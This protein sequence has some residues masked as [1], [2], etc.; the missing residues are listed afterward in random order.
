MRKI[1]YAMSSE[2]GKDYFTILEQ[3]NKV[4]LF[5]GKEVKKEIEISEENPISSIVYKNDTIVYTE[6]D[7]DDLYVCNVTTGVVVS[8]YNFEHYDKIYVLK[9]INNT[10]KVI[11]RA[12]RGRDAYFVLYDLEKD[13]T[14]CELEMRGK[15]YDFT[16]LQ[17]GSYI[18]LCKCEENVSMY[19]DDDDSETTHLLHFRCTDSGIEEIRKLM[20]FSSYDNFDERYRSCIMPTG[21]VRFPLFNQYMY[22][23]PVEKSLTAS[24]KHAVYYQEDI[25]GLV[26][27]DILTAD[28]NRILTLPD[29]CTEDNEYYYNDETGILSVLSGT[30]VIQY[31]IVERDG[32]YTERLNE[33]YNEAYKT[34][35]SLQKNFHF[36]RIL[37]VNIE[38]TICERM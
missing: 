21:D 30:E 6:D 3:G 34:K 14:I 33:M 16:I 32:G 15:F 25:K 7:K 20:V 13:K 12:Y 22:H 18:L 35:T 38:N 8:K 27:S 9:Y 17:D 28:V 5:E 10:E 1:R 19:E 11:L 24:G 29:S 37:F 2:R 26:I 23:W 31:L 4:L 36:K